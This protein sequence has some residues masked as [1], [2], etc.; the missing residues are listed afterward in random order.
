MRTSACFEYPSPVPK[1]PAQPALLD[2]LGRPIRALTYDQLK[3][4]PH[5]VLLLHR[6][7]TAAGVMHSGGPRQ[8]LVYV[9]F[10]LAFTAGIFFTPRLLPGVPPWL[11]G[12]ALGL[13][14]VVCLGVIQAALRT[15]DSGSLITTF[16]AHARCPGC[17]YTLASC[18]PDSH[19]VVMCPECGASWNA[20]RIGTA[21]VVDSP[22]PPGPRRYFTPVI[23]DDHQRVVELTP[24]SLR[25]TDHRLSPERA[26]LARIAV[27]DATLLR[28]I[29]TC[30]FLLVLIVLVSISAYWSRGAPLVLV[31][32]LG[33]IGIWGV[34]LVQN[35]RNRAPS[36]AGAIRKALLNLRVCP[37]CATDLNDHAPAPDGTT[38]CPTCAA[39]W[40]LASP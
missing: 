18:P 21:S 27:R 9:P 22:S 17:A 40:R 2:D 38:R 37:A 39:H 11:I 26:A 12:A 24:P 34:W 5:A 32:C 13:A 36:G 29:A 6:V 25:I 3:G 14:L 19:G 1:S 28:S 33:A 4:D 23:T 15:R 35:I 30:S 8:L 20:S 31:G 7:T 16:L 10:L